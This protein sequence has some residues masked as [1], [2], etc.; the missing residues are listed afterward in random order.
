MAIFK[1][2]KKEAAP[3]KATKKVATPKVAETTAGVKTTTTAHGIIIRPIVTE[4]AALAQGQSNKYSF[5][6]AL[7]AKKVQ[8]KTAIQ[9]MYGVKP[10]SVN[11]VNVQ[12]HRVRF[13]ASQGRKSDSRKAIVTLPAGQ[14]IAIH[15]G[16]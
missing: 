7:D 8:V 3:K 11:I 13:G 6:V 1:K 9:E 10:V 14:T 2:D 5:V 12:G 4:K 15:E 16:V